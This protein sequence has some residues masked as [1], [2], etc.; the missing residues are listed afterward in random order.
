MEPP[1]D[2][3]ATRRIGDPA[4]RHGHPQDDGARLR[5]AWWRTLSALSAV[6]A[7]ACVAGIVL[8]RPGLVLAP[9]PNWRDEER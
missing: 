1:S 3:A 7:A 2:L 9:P 8:G 6:L 5:A 4:Q